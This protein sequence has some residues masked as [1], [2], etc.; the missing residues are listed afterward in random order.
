MGARDG[1]EARW[2]VV[3]D[4]GQA[5]ASVLA[6]YDNRPA[7]ISELRAERLRQSGLRVLAVSMEEAEAIRG[8]LPTIGADVRQWFGELPAWT[9]VLSGPAANRRSAVQLND[10]VRTIEPGRLRL[11]AR[12][13]RLPGSSGAM[14][15]ELAPQLELA[16][17]LAWSLSR[18]LSV[19]SGKVEGPGAAGPMFESL[20][21]SWKIEPGTVYLIV[22]EAPDVSWSSLIAAD[23]PESDRP[24]PET[25]KI[26]VGPTP[27]TA[28]SLGEAM[29]GSADAKAG[30]RGPRAVL[31]LTPV[32]SS[33]WELLPG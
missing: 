22:P 27:P 30:L 26:G 25:S 8:G 2:W 16:S 33:G 5:L 11:L 14:R 6:E 15:L 28:P 9:P 23:R 24:E 10:G 18:S 17:K 19:A 13:Y 29:M 32:V 21:V 1:L 12:C 3:D 4:Q 31:V 20:G 7:P